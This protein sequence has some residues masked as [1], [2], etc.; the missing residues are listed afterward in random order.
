MPLAPD[1]LSVGSGFERFYRSQYRAVVG[2]VYALSGSRWAAE[3]LAQEAFLRAHQHWDKVS[4]YER[5]DA[6]LKRVAANLAMS[7]LRR[8]RV[9]VKALARWMTTQRSSFPALEPAA[10]EFWAMVRRLPRRQAEAVALFYLEDMSVRD[11]ATLLGVAESTVKTSLQRGRATLME[12][13]TEREGA[14]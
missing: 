2:L 9:E 7:H 4:G 1:A 12:R 3:D 13:L 11:I 10:E 14:R 8:M 6:W 5:P